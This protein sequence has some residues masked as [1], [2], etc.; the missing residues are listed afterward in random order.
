MSQDGRLVT[1]T[2]GEVSGLWSGYIGE[3][4]INCVMDSFLHNVVDRDAKRLLEHN[5]TLVKERIKKYREIFNQE[6]MKTPQGFG[7]QDVFLD[8]PRMFSDKFYMFYLK[9]MSRSS[10]INYMNAMFAS[11]R[12]DIRLFLLQ[13]MNE[14]ADVFNGAVE[15]LLEKGIVIRTPNIPIPTDIKFVED[16]SFLGKLKGP[17]RAISGAEI[18]ELYI[19]LDTNMLGKSL[20]IA[21]SQSAQSDD[22]KTYMLRGRKIAHKHIDIFINQLMEEDLPAPQLWDPEVTE[23]KTPPFSDK[24]MHYHS[25]LASASGM[26]NYGTALSQIAR[27]DLSLTFAR[28]ILE[29]AKFSSD[30]AVLSI[31]KGWLEEPPLASNRDQL[32]YN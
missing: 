18:K 32:F 23:S 29:T 13:N 30:G 8:A 28:L 22:L 2:S 17:Q 4:L 25:G 1:L 6:G 27:K 16:K 7:E 5:S 24:L 12:R 26:S 21:F 9:E 11:H 15:A 3:T 19:N 10:I 14:Y 31:D 20:M